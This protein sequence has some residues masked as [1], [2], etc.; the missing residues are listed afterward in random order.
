MKNPKLLNEKQRQQQQ[1]DALG[2]VHDYMM[3]RT[4]MADVLI[5]PKNFVKIAGKVDVNDFHLAAHRLIF[6]AIS[7][8]MHSPQT[9]D[10]NVVMHEVY[11]LDPEGTN[12]AIRIVGD[13][14]AHGQAVSN[15]VAHAQL[16]HNLS[17]LRQLEVHNREMIT[18]CQ[19]PQEDPEEIVQESIKI[20][21]KLIEHLGK[22]G[23]THVKE[24]VEKV[25][26][27]LEDEK[28]GIFKPKGLQVGF[29]SFDYSTGG[30][31]GGDLVVIAAMTGAGKSAYGGNIA[32]NLAR[33]G[34][35]VLIFSLEMSKLN[36]ADRFVFS[37]A[38]ISRDRRKQRNLDGD[39][40][41]QAI[42]SAHDIGKLPI[43][44]DA[45][46]PLTIS[47]LLLK[48]QQ[49]KMQYA[50]DCIIVDYIQLVTS[51]Q[52]SNANR[53]ERMGEISR[54][55]KLIA[56]NV[57]L[58]II[59][60]AQLNRKYT[61]REGVEGKKPGI[62]DIRESGSIENDAD[63]ITFLYRPD[64]FKIHEINGVSTRNRAI[65]IMA[66]VRNGSAGE[67]DL[68]FNQEYTLFEDI[69]PGE[70]TICSQPIHTDDEYLGDR[71]GASSDDMD[72]DNFE[73]LDADMF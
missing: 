54:S 11:R 23:I 73:E 49:A 12:D 68:R 14:I 55:L 40:Y 27:E 70:R 60:L 52:K 45:T 17:L 32:M 57:G 38:R 16:V 44:I 71:L 3:E 4:L 69:Q 64:K 67:F 2:S 15:V 30:L 31:V 72:D 65:G 28:K 62:G 20:Q 33:Q 56:M 53:D 24:A 29:R 36:I 42:S 51:G 26:Q 58:P 66:K 37:D 9:V 35:K 48:I 13:I 22:E 5:Y 46:A 50:I 6:Q 7:N 21:Y 47:Q 10:N 8:V 39:E 1:A 41:D 63:I 19:N 34:K 59:T 18:R 61:D 43:Y 25:A